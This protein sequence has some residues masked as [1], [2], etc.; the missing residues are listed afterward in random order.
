VDDH[1]GR[2]VFDIVPSLKDIA[3]PL[4]WKVLETG[5][6]AT[7]VEIEGETPQVPGVQRYWVEQFYPIKDGSGAVT[8]IGI[9]CV[10]VT[11]RR[12]AERAQ[13][14]LSREL[15]HRIKNLFAVMASIVRLS[16]RGNDA[17]QDFARTIGGRIEALG[18]AHDYVRPVGDPYGAADS[19]R[20]L[21]SLMNAILEP[22]ADD[23]ERISLTGEDPA[24]GS[25]AA[26]AL[27]LTIH[28]LATNA[29]KYGA[30]SMPGGTVEITCG[31]AGDTFDLV[32]AERGGPPID[33][34]PIRQGFGTTLARRSIA[35]EL[36]GTS[37]AE[38]ARDGLRLRISVPAERLGR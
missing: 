21:H 38:W 17:V 22:W 13:D 1:V 29:V 37:A 32:W 27:A 28:E 34:P 6:P 20:S 30:L 11:E 35:G 8:G 36:A 3:E 14:L 31:T 26:M 2:F 10:E 5:Q 19:P 12:H 23:G 18:R 16:A 25:A 33:R 24:I 7:D 4:F 15:S 9:V